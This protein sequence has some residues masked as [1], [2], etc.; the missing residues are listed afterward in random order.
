LAWTAAVD[1]TISS[2]VADYRWRDRAS[3]F[4]TGSLG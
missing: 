4:A 3:R 1:K 2:N